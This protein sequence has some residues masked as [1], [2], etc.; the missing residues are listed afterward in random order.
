M[1]ED[2]G[3]TVIGAVSVT[4]LWGNVIDLRLLATTKWLNLNSPLMQSGVN[5]SK[6]NNPE[7]G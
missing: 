4:T 6:G 5:W 3:G 1:G 7:W 2:F